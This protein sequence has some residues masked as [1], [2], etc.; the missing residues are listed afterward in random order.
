MLLF[1]YYHSVI[2][3]FSIVFPLS[4][5][6]IWVFHLFFLFVHLHEISL[7]FSIVWT[8]NDNPLNIKLLFIMFVSELVPTTSL[9]LRLRAHEWT[10]QKWDS[11]HNDIRFA[12]CL[13]VFRD[14]V[15][16][17]RVFPRLTLL[18][19]TTLNYQQT[20]EGSSKLLMLFWFRPNDGYHFT[21]LLICCRQNDSK[22]RQNDRVTN[23]IFYGN[24]MGSW[25]KRAE[26]Y[27][28]WKLE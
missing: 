25:N 14:N 1:S 24:G 12:S 21:E 8:R 22:W 9:S 11:S 17:F 4:S 15:V 7:F 3:F 27:K 2:A 28:L 6:L 19:Q 16:L 18:P 10:G 20:M 13:P 26:G 5:I 23:W